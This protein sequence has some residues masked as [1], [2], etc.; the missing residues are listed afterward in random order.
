M[1]N[2]A[3]KKT[4][5]IIATEIN[6]IKNQTINIVL[7]A[8]IEIGRRLIEA[9]E[10]VGHGN[11][12]NWL[13]ESVDYSERKANQLMQICKTYGEQQNSL[14]ITDN[15]ES[16]TG[17]GFDKLNYSQ[18]VALL[19]IKDDEDR[20]E[21]VKTH[22]IENM[23]KR[24]LEKAIKERDEQKQKA[25]ESQKELNGVLDRMREIKADKEKI[26]KEN[27]QKN[28]LL[29]E[30]L[31]RILKLKQELEKANQ[32]QPENKAELEE[33]LKAAQEKIKTMQDQLDQPVTV[34]PVTIEKVPEATEQE[35]KQLREQVEVMKN[36]QS[37][38]TEEKAVLK[39]R[40][41]FE[42]LSTNFN[43]ILSAISDIEDQE[44]KEKYTNATKKLIAVMGEKL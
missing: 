40:I 41:Y 28:K 20:K 23:S 38:T 12:I 26:E 2:I 15:A 17:C 8:S 13:Q 7:Q 33:Q 34:E 31:D 16:A 14:W 25:A 39:Y 43:Q 42:N 36:N 11:W 30:Q 10:V 27:K 29:D 9:K 21:F 22:D 4:P 5:E 3:V 32:L 18:A 1:S 37:A 19:V 6:S 44:T 24:E 35:L